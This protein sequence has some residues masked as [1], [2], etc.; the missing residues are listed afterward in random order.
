MLKKVIALVRVP[1]WLTGIG[2]LAFLVWWVLDDV[3][4]SPLVA[5]PSTVAFVVAAL[6]ARPPYLSRSPERRA[7]GWEF[8]PKAERRKWLNILDSISYKRRTIPPERLRIFSSKIAPIIVVVAAGLLFLTVRAEFE[9]VNSM[10]LKLCEQKIAVVLTLVIKVLVAGYFVRVILRCLSI[11]F[12]GLFVSSVGVALAVFLVFAK[13]QF[14][15]DLPQN[16]DAV[17]NY[18]PTVST[19]VYSAEGEL[20][21]NFTQ[22]DRIKVKAENIPELV[23]QVFI[24]AEDQN[25][26]SHHG[27]DPIAIVRAFAANFKSGQDG[28]GGST[29]TQQAVKMIILRSSEKKLVRKIREALLAIRIERQAAAKYG[30]SGGKQMILEAYLNQIY[31]GHRAYG[32][33]TASMSY[34][35][36]EL[37]QL[38]LAEASI[39]AGLPKAPSRDSPYSHFERAKFRQKYVLVRMVALGFITEAEKTK[40]VAE[41]IAVLGRERSINATSAP[42]FCAHV[43]FELE[44]LYGENFD[45]MGLT[46]HST[47]DMRMQRAAEASVR[48]GLLD[49]ERRLGWKGPDGERDL[50]F[51]GQCDGDPKLLADHVIE[52]ARIV[53]VGSGI[54]VCVRGATFEMD[55]ADVVRMRK[56]EQNAKKTLGRGDVLHVRAD[57][58]ELKPLTRSRRAVPMEQPKTVR[59]AL[60]AQRTAGKQALQAGMVV[61]DPKSGFLKAIVGGY[62][63]DESNF[64]SATQAKRQL[65]SSVKPYVYLTA[66]MNGTTVDAKLV[67]GPHCYPAP[68]P[69]GK[70]CPENYVGP[71]TRQQYMGL[72]DLM[73]A[74][75]KS[76]NSIS[77]QLA[78]KTGIDQVIKTMR[79]LGIKSE[80]VPVLAASIGTPQV[81]LWE[82]T[83]AYAI[84]AGGGKEMPK[85]P[86]AEQNGIFLREVVD[87]HGKVLY[88][89]EPSERRQVV[90]SADT[91]ALVHLMKGVVEM[92][93]GRRVKE[94]G[95]PAAGKTG[96]TNGF[97]DTWFM[98][99]TADC[100]VGVWLG[101]DTPSI[102]AEEATGGSVALPLWLAFMKASHPDTPTREFAVPNDVILT[103]SDSGEM[104]PYQLGRLPLVK[105]APFS[106]KTN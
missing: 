54:K 28:Q 32:I 3:V 19:R 15:A 96:T 39:L 61:V 16:L 94:L 30:V 42:Y 72:V 33:Q 82:H 36:K 7:F 95:R 66:L 87:A 79:L 71:H 74:L 104:I 99:F 18:D 51:T 81:S 65:G 57:T 6:L 2:C 67:D 59:Y 1:L 69:S 101:R 5:I 84:I 53:S 92:G 47:I 38:T 86:E 35:G 11:R 22:Q 98:G 41:D 44:R 91:Y 100:V 62:D 106:E 103:E 21:C 68:T 27:V 13:Q 31:L 93:T 43:A 88:A 70:W 73:T 97:F 48:L 9:F 26:Y 80:I 10:F 77:I 46:V 24:A 8:K 90:P 23:K 34:F 49:L 63:W 20:V 40:A 76:L 45:E 102:I 75:A 37:D 52:S 58:R 50:N 60:L 25:F 4:A 89:Y 83:Y 29:L 56:W 85:H 12:I 17:L 14:E 64:N 55:P 78:A 105:I